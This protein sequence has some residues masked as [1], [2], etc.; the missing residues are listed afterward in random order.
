MQINKQFILSAI[1]ISVVYSAKAQ[2]STP[3]SELG[4]GTYNSVKYSSNFAMGGLGAAYRSSVYLNPLSPASLSEI[5]FTN[6]EAGVHIAQNRLQSNVGDAQYTD[7]NLSAFSFGFPLGKNIGLAAGALPYTQ[8]NYQN[9]S[10]EPFFNTINATT[11][12][13]G[14]GN[15]TDAYIALGLKLKALSLGAKASYLFGEIQDNVSLQFDNSN[16][17]NLRRR[18]FNTI[19]G[20]NLDVGAQL[21]IK[22]GEDKRW[23]LGGNTGLF[24]YVNRY[25]YIKVNDY[26]LQNTADGGGNPIT[27]ANHNGGTELINTY[28]DKQAEQFDLP[29]FFNGGISFA[30][31]QNYLWGVQYDYLELKDFQINNGANTL[32]LGQKLTFGGEWTPNVNA[33]GYG[34]FWRTMNYRMGI[35]AGEAPYKIN[36]EQIY[37]YGINFGFSA[38]L[39]KRQFEGERFGSYINLALGYGY[40]GNDLIIN[41]HIFHLNVSVVL[42]DKWFVKRKYN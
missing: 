37:E 6:G 36:D 33:G 2:V 31:N 1:F 32:S 10:S 7:F 19:R 39:S 38:P 12:Y 13:E 4:L 25:H 14:S 26:L 22:K 16:F 24:N 18:D 9:A 42:N 40:R 27:I 29:F 21:E 17:L 20:F 11:I 8:K 35:Y 23:I 34:K 15:V 41:E 3:F 30:K 28:E 5:Q